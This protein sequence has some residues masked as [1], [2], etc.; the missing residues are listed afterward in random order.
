VAL[1]PY[2]DVY[3]RTA[4]QRVTGRLGLDWRPDPELLLGLYVAAAFV[5]YTVGVP[6]AYGTAGASIGWTPWTIATLNLGAFSQSQFQGAAA[7]AG[8]FRQWTGYFSV[9]LRDIISL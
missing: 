1:A 4:Y 9:T 2:V 3:L 6:D 5:P 7:T 8:V